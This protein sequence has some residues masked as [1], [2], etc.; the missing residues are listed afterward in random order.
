MPPETV[1]Y[2]SGGSG[3]PRGNSESIAPAEQC[4]GSI[5]Q[6]AAT[7]WTCDVAFFNRFR[8]N[9]LKGEA[10]AKRHEEAGMH[11]ASE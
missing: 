9:R 3:K 7:L 2:T 4:G 6:G 1:L 10:L 5:L 8:R 11:G